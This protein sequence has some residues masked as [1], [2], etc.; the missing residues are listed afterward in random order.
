MKAD[1][2]K[3]LV[4][5]YWRFEKGYPIVASEYNYGD[6]DIIAVSEGRMIVCETEVKVSIAD[7]KR[8]R[9]KTKH[10]KD[11]FGEPFYNTKFVNYFYFAIPSRILEKARLI[12]SQ[13]FPYAGILV[14]NNFNSYLKEP[15]ASYINPPVK[16]VKPA[17]A[18]KTSYGRLSDDTF[19]TIVRGMGN[20]LCKLAI[21]NMKLERGLK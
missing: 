10:Q 9:Y 14:V 18:N 1:D 3:K 8:E 15:R 12:C 2:I 16:C 4:M 21:E 20:N 17:K 7:L 13:L 11:A 5:V 6:K 19:I